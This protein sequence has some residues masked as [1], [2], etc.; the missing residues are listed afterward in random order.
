MEA[1]WKSISRATSAF[2]TDTAVELWV[3]L[4]AETVQRYA[5]SF[6]V[7]GSNSMFQRGI[8]FYF[9]SYIPLCI[10]SE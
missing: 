4:V 8:L 2:M 1:K 6:K 3:D 7:S 9:L 10:L 5:H